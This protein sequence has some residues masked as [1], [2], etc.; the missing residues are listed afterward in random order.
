VVVVRRGNARFGEGP[1]PEGSPLTQAEIDTINDGTWKA[2]ALWAESVPGAELI[3]VPDTTHYVFTE[4][5]D[6]VV[7]AIRAAIARV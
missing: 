3:T 6:A 1:L 7:A 4:R 2:Q 5:P